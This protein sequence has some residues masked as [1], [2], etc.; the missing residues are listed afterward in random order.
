MTDGNEAFGGEH[1]VVYTDSEL[2]C[3]PPETYIMLSA[4][5]TLIE[6]HSNL[7]KKRELA[8]PRRGS[9]SL[10]RKDFGVVRHQNTHI[11]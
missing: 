7:K 1:T 11:K 9:V 3:C 2:Q 8:H 6:K 4:N 10:D 5:V